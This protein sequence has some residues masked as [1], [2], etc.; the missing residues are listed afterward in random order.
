MRSY[1]LPHVSDK[2]RITVYTRSPLVSFIPFLSRL[3]NTVSPGKDILCL[4][5][6]YEKG[7]SRRVLEI[8]TWKRT[9]GHRGHMSSRDSRV[10]GQHASTSALLT[11]DWL[12]V[13]LL[14]SVYFHGSTEFLKKFNFFNFFYSFWYSNIKNN[15]KK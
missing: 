14:G 8:M 11:E 10:Q 6:W 12:Q 13:C 4:R 1:F 15:L 7:P 2:S 5:L 9:L 3:I